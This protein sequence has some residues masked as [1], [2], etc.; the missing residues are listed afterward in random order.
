MHGAAS[1]RTGVQRVILRV[2]QGDVKATAQIA[3]NGIGQ[4][5]VGVG[6]PGV[7]VQEPA[8]IGPQPGAHLTRYQVAVYS[9]PRQRRPHPG[10]CQ[11]PCSHA[12]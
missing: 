1:L 12:L 10:Y 9:A 4:R 7:E 11:R 6:T 5:R 2:F 8:V 3:G